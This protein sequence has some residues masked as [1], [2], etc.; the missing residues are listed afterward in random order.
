[1]KSAVI[2]LLWL[3]FSSFFSFDVVARSESRL[4]VLFISIDDLR[5]N[6]GCYGD[7]IAVTPRI[8]HLAKTGLTFERAYC[9]QAVCNPSRQSFMSGRRPDSIRVWNMVDHFRQT[10]PDVVTLPEHFKKHGYFARSFGKIYHGQTGMNDPQSWSVPEQFD[11]SDKIEDYGQKPEEGSRKKNQAKQTAALIANNA[12][13]DYADGKIAIAAIDA[14][15]EFNR[16]D[17][18]FFLA[19]GF[20]K[21]HLP[22]A[23]PKK[24][25]ELYDPAKIPAPTPVMPPKDVPA[26]ALHEWNELRGYV[27]MPKEGPVSSEKA[28]ELRHGYYAATSF[29]D[30]QVGKVLDELERLGLHE[31][32]IVVLFSDHGFHLGEHGLWAKASN[33]E[34]DA[35]VP[36]VIRVPNQK[37]AGRKTKALVELVDLFPTLTELCGLPRPPKLD[38]VSLVP[39]LANPRGK[40]KEFALSQFPRP[41]QLNQQPQKMGYAMR[42]D[43]WR[44]V[45][46]IDFQTRAILDRE[47]YDLQT[48]LNEHVNLADHPQQ[49]MRVAELSRQ[50]NISLDHTSGP[51]LKKSNSPTPGEAPQ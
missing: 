6:L 16:N 4:N 43:R 26:I 3:F 12:D 1:M 36:L 23:A 45:E 49:A 7:G 2:I 38:G 8:D 41:W 29:M 14:L 39:L 15:R 51:L 25:W 40:V 34:L 50:L 42:T 5:T 44:Y 19:V 10:A 13:A 17:T 31:N 35:R 21:P 9:Q 22:F 33:F 47:L 20:R 28:R 11:H 30:A 27:D 37:A 24:Y 18:P 32:T 46:W 48:D